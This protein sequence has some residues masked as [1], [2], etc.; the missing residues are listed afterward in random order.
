MEEAAAVISALLSSLE[1][2]DER[3]HTFGSIVRLAFHDAGTFDGATGGAD[4]CVDHS[5][6]ENRGLAD[7]EAQLAQAVSTVTGRLSKADVWAL[8]AHMVIDHFASGPPLEYQI[9]RTDA[10][11]CEGH[12]ERLPNAELTHT[13]ITDV[14]VTGLGFTE[15]ETAALMGAHVLGRANL[16]I[17]GYDGSWVPRGDQFTNRY[18]RDVLNRRWEKEQATINGETRTTWDGPRNTIMLNTDIN[19]AF[20]TASCTV[21][22]GRNGNCPRA[23]HGFSAAV[24]DFAGPRNNPRQGEEAFFAAFPPAFKK[25][26]A[27]GS[28]GLECAYTDCRTPTGA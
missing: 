11:S 24:T 14:F 1:T 28:S 12:G 5:L 15:R 7:V 18:F 8:A 3:E 6:G 4:G 26:M 21:A 20:D 23:T 16:D 2:D 17:S 9:G 10:A 22:G 13:H 25:L 27:L 19:L